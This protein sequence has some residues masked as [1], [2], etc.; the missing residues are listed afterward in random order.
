MSNTATNPLYEK[1]QKEFQQYKRYQSV[2]DKKEKAL[3]ESKADIAKILIE[4]E[5]EED[6][7]QTAFEVFTEIT[8]YRNDL[9]VIGHRL[10]I[11]TDG[12]TELPELEPKIPQEILEVCK[13]LE[14]SL[15]KNNFYV[16]ED[17][18]I[19]EKEKDF[20]KKVK[21]TQVKSGAMKELISHLKSMLDI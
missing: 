3:E 5:F 9:R 18:N 13:G 7:E 16:D 21:E 20:L 2:I 15:P 11:L 12:Y 6:V 8:L 14:A 4:S 19:I 17:M 1:I 10:Y